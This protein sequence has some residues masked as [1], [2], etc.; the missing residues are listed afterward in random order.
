MSGRG[1]SA[2]RTRGMPRFAS[3]SSYSW[4]RT[5]WQE[6]MSEASIQRVVRNGR[7]VRHCLDLSIA[8]GRLTGIG[9]DLVEALLR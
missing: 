7:Y 1:V 6:S 5:V 8:A 2:V 9:T 3:R 4:I